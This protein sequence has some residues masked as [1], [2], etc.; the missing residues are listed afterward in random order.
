MYANRNDLP[1]AAMT[2]QLGYTLRIG[3]TAIS[4]KVMKKEP[5][6]KWSLKF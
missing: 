3:G 2:Y 1:I 6:G 5:F 4:V